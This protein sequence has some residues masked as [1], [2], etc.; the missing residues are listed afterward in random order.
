VPYDSTIFTV[1][2]S[3]RSFFALLL[4]VLPPRRPISSY[5]Q[6]KE[7]ATWADSSHSSAPRPGL[8]TAHE[9]CLFAARLV[10][11]YLLFYPSQSATFK[12]SQPGTSPAAP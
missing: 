4:P 8:N 6:V 5:L 3:L 1:L 10:I 12:I 7:A 2:F 11:P 9:C